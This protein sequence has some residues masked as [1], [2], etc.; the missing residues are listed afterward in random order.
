MI[1]NGRSSAKSCSLWKVFGSKSGLEGIQ[2]ATTK[3][4]NI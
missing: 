1:Y 2:T 3:N 4:D